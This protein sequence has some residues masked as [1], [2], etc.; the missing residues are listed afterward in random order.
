[1]ITNIS[2]KFESSF[3]RCPI[4]RIVNKNNVIRSQAILASSHRSEHF[5]HPIDHNKQTAY[6]HAKLFYFYINDVHYL[7]ALHWSSYV[8]YQLLLA[9]DFEFVTLE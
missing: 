2:G 3:H 8:C 7:K 6:K 9:N 5:P 1:M 4:A